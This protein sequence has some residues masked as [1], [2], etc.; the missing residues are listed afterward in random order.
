M[1]FCPGEKASPSFWDMMKNGMLFSSISMIRLFAN[2]DIRKLIKAT[3]KEKKKLKTG[4]FLYLMLMGVAPEHQRKGY[5]T[6]LLV[7]L[8][9]R[10]D[11]EKKA[12]YL[13]IQNEMNVQWYEKFGF[14]VVKQIPIFDWLTL[15][16]MVREAN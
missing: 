1:V 15:W 5:G 3:E 9:K 4:P 13:E 14:K 2:R 7:Y 12:I 11:R 10:A 6:Q 16:R 8:C